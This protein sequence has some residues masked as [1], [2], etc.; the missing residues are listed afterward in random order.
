M[1]V[2]RG[3]QEATVK[4]ELTAQESVNTLAEPRASSVGVVDI[5]EDGEIVGVPGSVAE[6][7]LNKSQ[8]FVRL[9]EALQRPG[10]ARACDLMD[11]F[12]LD[13][14]TLRRY[15]ADLREIDLPLNTEGRG[16]TRRLWIDASYRRHGVRISLLELISL[17]FGRQAF[18][19]LEG[20]TFASDMDGA[21]EALSTF[22]HRGAAAVR[23]LD[24]KFVAIPEHRKDHARDNDVLEE[25]LTAVVYENPAVAHYARLT[26]PTKEYRLLPLSLVVF[27][28]SLYL[29]ARDEEANL[30]K[31]FAIDRFRHFEAQRKEHF[32][33]PADY[34]P[35]QQYADAFG[36][37]KGPVE[38]VSLR[39][40]RRAA[41]YIRERIWHRSQHV[42]ELRDGGVRLTMQVGVQPELV[43]WVLSFGPD[44]QVEAPRELADKIRRLHREAAEG[45]ELPDPRSER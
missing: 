4:N 40:N 5:A 42:E 23:H 8:K 3:T 41:P 45:F 16:D 32:E 19:F 7:D 36:I 33:Y 13:D 26:G 11:R 22:A 24:R 44:V 1:A 15:L 27:K 38:A 30:I 12:G 29:F 28:Q 43:S 2:R 9:I 31:T 25:V 17:R 37:M 21:L 20:T 34:D 39:F 10:G 18:G 14:R 35:A 6:I